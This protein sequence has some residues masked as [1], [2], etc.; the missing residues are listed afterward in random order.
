MAPL[1]VADINGSAPVSRRPRKNA[2][3]AVVTARVPRA[4]RQHGD[5]ILR[6][7]GSTPTKLI[8]AAYDYVIQHK[9]LPGEQ[10]SSDRPKPGVRR[11]TPEQAKEF[12]ALLA[13]TTVGALDWEGKT[14]D[15]LKEEALR[16]KHPERFAR[17]GER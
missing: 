15:D 11:F 3:D 17:A 2:V 14:Y 8:N 5:D 9:R 10:L 4:V 13:R 7:M 16:G 1:A 6:E 12:R